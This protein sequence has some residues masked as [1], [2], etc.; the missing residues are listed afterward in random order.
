MKKSPRTTE[1]F[2]AGIRPIE[3][4]F[5]HQRRRMRELWFAGDLTGARGEIISRA[6]ASGLPVHETSQKR[7]SERMPD[8]NHQGLIARI[9]PVE[10][11]EWAQLLE[12]P[13]GLIVAIDQVT[14][15]R[16]LGAILRAGE[17]MGITG[18]LLTSNRCARL[19]PVVTRISAGA[20][21]LVPVAMEPNLHRALKKAQ[22]AGFQVVGADLDGVAPD[23]IALQL[24]TILVIGAEG[25]GLRRLTYKTCDAIATI[26]MA[27][28]T[29]SLNAATAAGILV[30]EA[31]QQR[32]K[33]DLRTESTEIS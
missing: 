23:Q 20:S 8:L 24:P 29:E 21:E 15:P 27:G 30:Y 26:R 13:N 14:D 4:I 31:S 17:A 32:R 18:A 2:I 22:D 6:R 9:D 19:G 11:M 25:K 12:N 7:L 3:A 16:N 28:T 33:I 5:N 1:T 10:Y